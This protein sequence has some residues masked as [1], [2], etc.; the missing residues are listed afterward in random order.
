MKGLLL[1]VAVIQSMTVAETVLAQSL[2]CATDRPICPDDGSAPSG[3]FPD[4]S[5]P[6]P[7]SCGDFPDF[8]YSC[9]FDNLSFAWSCVCTDNRQPAH[10]NQAETTRRLIG[11]ATMLVAACAIAFVTAAHFATSHL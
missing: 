4:C 11:A 6:K 1:A 3:N 9:S 7:S 8:S 5:C 10:L 2:D